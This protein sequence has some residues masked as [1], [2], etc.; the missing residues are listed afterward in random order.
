M[1]FALGNNQMISA[2]DTNDGVKV[3]SIPDGSPTG[4]PLSVRRL[5]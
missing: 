1:G 4:E 5:N 3:T 2:L